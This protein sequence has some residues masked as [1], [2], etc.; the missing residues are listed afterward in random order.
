MENKSFFSGGLDRDTDERLIKPD[1]YRYA[2][3]IRNISSES[4]DVGAIENLKGNVQ[5]SFTLPSGDNKTIGTVEDPVDSSLFYFVWNSEGN[6]SILEYNSKVNSVTKILQNKGLRFIKNQLITSANIVRTSKSDPDNNSLDMKQ[7]LLYWTDDVNPPRKINV[8]KAQKHQAEF[9]ANGSG[10][11]YGSEMYGKGLNNFFQSNFVA[12]NDIQERYINAIKYAPVKRATT[13]FGS[14]L[15][16]HTNNVK[17]TM[18]QFSYRYIYDDGEVSPIAPWSDIAVSE[19][20][21]LNQLGKGA[22]LP[23]LDNKI[24]VTVFNWIDTVKKIEVLAREGNNPD[25]NVLIID[26]IDN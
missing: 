24:E 5:V 6:H 20:L 7:R 21:A 17:T 2:L 23:Y 1:S 11:T 8:E 9:D 18:F 26:T 22:N 10:G 4:S 3:N 25:N 14:D 16:V 19:D 12:N 13:A 15:L